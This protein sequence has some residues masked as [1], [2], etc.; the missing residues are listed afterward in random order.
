MMVNFMENNNYSEGW[1]RITICGGGNG[2]HALMSL[3]TENC[4]CQVTLYLPF[5]KELQ[6]FQGVEDER[7]PFTLI[8]KGKEF[9]VPMDRLFITS[10][11]KEAAAADL[12]ILVVPA[13]A[14][15]DILNAL[16]PYFQPGT[17]LAA[18]PARGGFEFQAVEAL[19]QNRKEGIII[20]GFQT[21]PWACR[22]REYAKSVEIYGQKRRVGIAS[23][24]SHYVGSISRVFN[25]FLKLKFLPYNNMLE[26]TLSNQGQIIHPG[27]MYGAFSNKLS[28]LYRRDEIP[29]FYRSVD[30]K[31]ANLLE[32][33]SKEILKVKKTIEDNFSLKLEA[34]ISTSQW[35]IESY[36]GDI[37]DNS[38]LFKMF[39]TN[40]SYQSL[41]VPVK[42]VDGLYQIDVKSRYLTEDIPY[43][44]LVSKAIADLANV[45]T[46][47]IDEVIERTSKWK[48]V[49]YLIN[50]ELKG[51]D[52]VKTRIPQNFGLTSL[53]AIIEMVTKN[54]LQSSILVRRK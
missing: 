50:G 32:A 27:I 11:P 42:P 45:S 34:V 16:A 8:F 23:L 20:A 39:Q 3:L 22:I 38:T 49:Q 52:L 40:L 18:L 29:L 2:A 46:P 15:R 33:M 54:H 44:L 41:R 37:K 9:S 6:R 26:L 4:R 47:R 43:G 1:E 5:D 19:R 53:K 51:K 36:E 25:K 21:L 13:F 35:M 10:N 12:I 28:K 31:T 17:V 30:E 24:P 14:H 7:V 48:G